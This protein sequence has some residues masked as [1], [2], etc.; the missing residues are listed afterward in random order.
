M[1]LQPNRRDGAAKGNHRIMTAIH[2]RYRRF[3][4]RFRESASDSTATPIANV[5]A[6]NATG[7]GGDLTESKRPDDSLATPSRQPSRFVRQP[8]KIHLIPRWRLVR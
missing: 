2:Y 8:V 4:M 5:R 3:E 6:T 7:V 1:L